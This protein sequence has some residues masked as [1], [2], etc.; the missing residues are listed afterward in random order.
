MVN[1]TSVSFFH[2]AEIPKVREVGDTKKL[3]FISPVLPAG[4]IKLISLS[5]HIS[6][7]VLSL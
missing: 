2:K 1:D 3:T 6:G 7:Q 5:F 4:T